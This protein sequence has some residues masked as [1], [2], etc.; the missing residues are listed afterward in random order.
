MY[1]IKQILLQG[2]PE[3]HRVNVIYSPGYPDQRIDGLPLS[4]LNRHPAIVG[5]MYVYVPSLGGDTSFEAFQELVAHLRAPDGV[6]GIES[7]PTSLYGI[8]FLKRHMR[9]WKLWIMKIP[10]L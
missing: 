1:K 4:D 2:Y 9:L 5:T 10:P 3:R 8:I 7:K 6:H